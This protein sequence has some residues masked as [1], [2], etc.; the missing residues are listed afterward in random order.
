MRKYGMLIFWQRY[1][2]SCMPTRKPDNPHCH[3]GDFAKFCGLLRIYELQCCPPPGFSDLLTA[4]N[5]GLAGWLLVLLATT[6][7]TAVLPCY[8][9]PGRPRHF[10]IRFGYYLPQLLNIDYLRWLVF[11]Q[12]TSTFVALTNQTTS[13]QD[14]QNNLDSIF[15]DRHSESNSG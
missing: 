15:S 4:L 9:N 5:G 1:F 14:D 13:K 2:Q 10:F 12:F 6:T 7:A 8:S 3:S 11:K